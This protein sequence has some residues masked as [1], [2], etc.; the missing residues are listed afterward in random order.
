[1]LGS[2]EA[3]VDYML[4]L[5]LHHLMVEGH[6][7]GPDPGFNNA[8]RRD[9]NNVY[10]H[11]ADAE[12]VGYPRNSRGSNHTSQYRSPLCEQFDALETCPEKFLLWFHHVAW[13][14]R[15]SSGRTLWEE[16]QFRYQRGVESAEAMEKT[17][18]TL[19]GKVDAQRF[20]HVSQRLAHQVENGRVWRD[21]CFAYFGQ[22]VGGKS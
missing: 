6:H 22:F 21:L 10:Y 3:C 16:L 2:W 12:G 5:G 15:L 4:P 17:W 18:H 14:Q 9:W 19:E 7:Y 20:E 1:M 13:G 8:P 11:R